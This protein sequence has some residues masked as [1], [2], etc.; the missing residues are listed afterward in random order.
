MVDDMMI[1][2]RS[3][4]SWQEYKE[5]AANTCYSVILIGIALVLLRPVMVRQILSRAEAYSSVGLVDESR[6]ECDKALLIDGESGHAWYQLAR[7]YKAAGDREKAYAAYQ[8][9]TQVDPKNKLA[10]FELGMMYSDDGSYPSA[11]PCFEQVRALGPE[12]ARDL[13]LGTPPYHRDSLNMLALCYEKTDDSTKLEFALEEINI[14]Y[15]GFGNAEQRLAQLKNGSP[16][17]KR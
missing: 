1:Y 9:A 16:A 7:L 6:R 3:R 2:P 11:I 4:R 15:P 13:Q 14:F 12:K 10:Q 5:F 17:G 8:K